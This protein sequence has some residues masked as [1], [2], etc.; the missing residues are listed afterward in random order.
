MLRECQCIKDLSLAQEVYRRKTWA[1][2][3]FSM[4]VNLWRH[5]CSTVAVTTED[6]SP[7][8]HTDTTVKRQLLF[9]IRSSLECAVHSW[10]CT[11]H[12]QTPATRAKRPFSFTAESYSE[13][14][15][16]DSLVSYPDRQ[17]I[18][19]SRSQDGQADHINYRNK[20][21]ETVL[22]KLTVTSDVNTTLET[23][24]SRWPEVFMPLLYICSCF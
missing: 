11:I 1:W 15:I 21:L 20:S 22:R 23:L 2:V 12:V 6:Q 3:F 16:D 13:A 14:G 7:A 18:W 24:K 8:P 10:S 4:K 9:S 19:P 17:Y 5:S